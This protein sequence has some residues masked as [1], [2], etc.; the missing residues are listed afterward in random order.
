MTF[1]SLLATLL[2]VDTALGWTLP[3]VR[4]PN[5][6]SLAVL[7]NAKEEAKI[8]ES[9]G[10]EMPSDRHLT[11]AAAAGGAAGPDAPVALGA[12][13]EAAAKK[14]SFEE[15]QALGAQ[16]AALLSESCAQ[17]QPMPPEAVTVLRVLISSTSG[18]RGWFV[19]LLTNPDFEAVFRPPLDESLLSA[20]SDNPDP[21]IK[22]MT[23]NVAMSTATE[24]VHEANGNPEL[25]AASRMTRDRSRICLSRSLIACQGCGRRS[26]ASS[27]PSSR[28]RR[29]TPASRCRAPMRMPSGSSSPRSG[30]TT[31]ISEPR[32]GVRSR[33]SSGS[34]C[35]EYCTA[36]RRT[37]SFC[38]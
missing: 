12:D 38:V 7:M 17:G 15:A 36:R 19:T 23:M 3:A 29:T 28:G 18:A 9:L 34:P 31:P 13:A 11:V 27:P 6:R 35:R 20:I 10:G 26:Q 32:S 5:T 4:P 30:G 25:A 22:L 37:R 33:L 24:L 1:H 8:R 14:A 21:N 2:L 16:L